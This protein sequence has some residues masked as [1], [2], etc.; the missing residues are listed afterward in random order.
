MTDRADSPK[1][2]ALDAGR[3]NEHGIEDVSEDIHGRLDRLESLV[4]HR[5]HCV[6]Q[7]TASRSSD[8]G[9]ASSTRS[10]VR[11]AA[12]GSSRRKS[13]SV[14][15]T[16]AACVGTCCPEVLLIV[17]DQQMV[18]SFTVRKQLLVV[19]SLAE[20]IARTDDLVPVRPKDGTE[21]PR[22]VFVDQK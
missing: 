12:S 7:T 1:F 13:E 9:Y 10:I 17:G 18:L 21:H 6:S 8:S 3:G 15:T 19:R 5:R 2:T 14:Y 4:D 11:T 16:T 20:D 22:N